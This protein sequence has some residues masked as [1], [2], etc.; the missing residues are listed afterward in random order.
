MSGVPC[1]VLGGVE[2]RL[3]SEEWRKWL[4]ER[5]GGCRGRKGPGV[6]IG[7]GLLRI[8]DGGP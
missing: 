5:Q 7:A 8:L 3:V 1:L 6:I 2:R 4:S